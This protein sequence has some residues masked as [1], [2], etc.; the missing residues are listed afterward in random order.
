V[1]FVAGFLLA[2]FLL[3]M[4]CLIFGALLL[5]GLK[6]DDASDP[7]QPAPVLPMP[8][9][10]PPEPLKPPVPQPIAIR[11]VNEEGR[12]LETIRIL[13]GHR[14]PVLRYRTKR[15]GQLGIFVAARMLP[16]G[17]WEY[18]RVNVERED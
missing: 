6:A 2:G 1:S 3:A 7:P 14:R 17:Q 16:S 4:L 11:L 10:A 18:R 9:A 13:P 12:E 5:S 8:A 15:N